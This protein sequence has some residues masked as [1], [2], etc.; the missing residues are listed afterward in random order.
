MSTHIPGRTMSWLGPAVIVLTGAVLIFGNPIGRE[1][2]CDRTQ[3]CFATWVGALSGWVG[4]IATLATLLFLIRQQ[5]QNLSVLIIPKVNLCIG[6]WHDGEAIRLAC[7]D[8]NQARIDLLKG[9]PQAQV[10]AET[11]LVRMEELYGSRLLERFHSEV[12]NIRGARNT[13]MHT[14]DCAKRATRAEPLNT[15]KAA[16]LI[17][18]AVTA[19]GTY[20]REI[21]RHSRIYRDALEKI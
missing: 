7:K 20:A 19:A 1:M 10:F 3:N 12:G 11:E 15:R 17:Q 16:H 21:K 14:L 9:A 5:H 8:L 4:A 13:A 2:V 18:N 6:A